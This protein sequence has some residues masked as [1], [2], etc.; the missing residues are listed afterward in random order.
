VTEKVSIA[1]VDPVVLLAQPL[2]AFAPTAA[3]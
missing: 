1:L 2:P 3:E